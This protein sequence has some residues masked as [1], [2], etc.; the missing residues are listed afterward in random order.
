[1]L[2]C[3]DQ[4]LVRRDMSFFDEM[5]N[6]YFKS[7]RD[8]RML[9]FPWGR[10]GRG[11]VVASREDYERKH[12]RLGILITIWLV[13]VV[14]MVFWNYGLAF[15]ALD[16]GIAL[17]AAWVFYAVGSLNPSEERLPVVRRGL[18]NRG[19]VTAFF[20]LGQL[21]TLTGFGLSIF[22]LVVKPGNRLVTVAILAFFVLCSVA[23][24]RLL[25]LW[26]QVGFDG[27]AE[28]MGA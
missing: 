8:G 23:V 7:A 1:M 18:A 5:G 3:D 13:L 4:A 16:L 28:R 14:V 27:P 10:L 12:R 6:R 20:W 2:D 19:V 11:Y 25:I 26:R 22:V 24:A 9:F 21:T 15:I 17:Y